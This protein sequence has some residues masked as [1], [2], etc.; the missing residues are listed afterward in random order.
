MDAIPR[1]FLFPVR[2]R[3]ISGLSK[4]VLI[5]EATLKS[6]S[7]ITAKLA[8]DQN[9]DVFAVPGNID[10]P[11]SKGP[12]YLIQQGAKPVTASTDILTEYGLRINHKR[13]AFPHLSLKE[14]KILDLMEE[15]E[16]KG[17]DYFVERLDFST[18]E[19]IAIIMGLVLKNLI[20]EEAGLYKKI[21]Y[22]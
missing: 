12:N 2:N 4:G 8:L 5:A 16:L 1:P 14:K 10:A 3:I 18:A 13:E 11:L 22:G 6:G 15:N 21:D 17:I 20:I 9:R 7:L 19:I